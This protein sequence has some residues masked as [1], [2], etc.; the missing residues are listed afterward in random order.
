MASLA[1]RNLFH[2]KIRL[3]ATLTG[4][5]FAVVLVGVQIGLFIGFLTATSNLIENSSADLWVMSEGV[6]Y[7]EI[8]QAFSERKRYQVLA[9]PGVARADKFV[10]RFAQWKLPSGAEE[11]ILVVGYDVDSGL[12][13]PWNVIEGDP[14]DLKQENTVMIDKLYRAK[15]GVDRVGQMVEINGYRARVVG[16][17][18]G[19]R[20]FTTSPAVFASFKNAQNYANF[21]EDETTFLLVAVQPGA[22]V[23]AVRQAI[24]E[25][26]QNVDVHTTKEFASMTA[27]YW[28]F[29]TGAGVTVLIAA[30][31]GLIVGVVVVAQTI[32]SATVDHLREFGTL[33]AMGATNGYIYRVIVKQALISAVLGYT[34][35]ILIAYGAVFASRDGGA[36][37]I[38]PPAVG[39]GLFALT[40]VMCVTAALVSINRV[41][42][43]DPA[44]VFKG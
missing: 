24:A 2:D 8:G 13:G 31:L 42:R 26:V 28:L 27:E 33:K 41:T 15:L 18:E 19:I 6:S 14:H 35:G 7:V 30:V 39:A 32:Y 9:V 4:V 16:F 38:L 34:F 43:I 40:L 5:V 29:G 22:D 25:R 10:V 44:M 20:T 36:A 3:A 37:I 23:A 11:G 21:N 17:T 12:G 1:L